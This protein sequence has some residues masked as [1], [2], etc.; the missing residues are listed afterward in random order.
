MGSYNIQVVFGEN[1]RR[2]RRENKLSQEELAELTNLHRVHLGRIERG[3]TNPPL[4]TM[5]K[6]AQALHVK[7]QDLLSS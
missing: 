2:V 4:A 7:V 6:I 1:V 3:E 5:N